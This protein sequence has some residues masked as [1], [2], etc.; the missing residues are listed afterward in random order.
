MLSSFSSPPC[1]DWEQLVSF[2]QGL[3]SLLKKETTI[4]GKKGEKNACVKEM[5]G[6][7]NQTVL[8]MQQV[9]SWRQFKQAMVFFSFTGVT[10]KEDWLLI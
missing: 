10:V 1:L 5:T 4:S 8:L 7:A 9:F 2:S 6:E 3:F